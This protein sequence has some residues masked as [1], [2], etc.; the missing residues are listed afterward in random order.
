V[1]M[2]PNRTIRTDCLKIHS[3]AANIFPGTEMTTSANPRPT[4]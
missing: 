1:D 3:V 2:T 4:L